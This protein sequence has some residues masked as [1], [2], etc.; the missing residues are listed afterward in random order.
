MELFKGEC[1][2][3][4]YALVA[5]LT[6]RMHEAGHKME[7]VFYDN[8]CKLRA[9]ALKKKFFAPARDGESTFGPLL[10]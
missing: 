9:L 1:L 4:V 10:V 6:Q 7:V 8:A 5:E 3:V 2:E